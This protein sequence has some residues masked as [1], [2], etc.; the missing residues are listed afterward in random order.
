MPLNKWNRDELIV[1]FNLYCR[2]P[3]GR[4]HTGNSE[5]IHLA[6]AIGRTP[7]AVSWKMVNFA[8]LDP[9][10][11]RTGRVG[12]T[13]GSKS[14]ADVWDEFSQDWD[15]LAVESAMLLAQMEFR[16]MAEIL[17]QE[18]AATLPEGRMREALVKVRIGQSFF[19]ASVLAAYDFRCCISGLTVPELLN[20]GHI[21]PWS[22]DSAQRT[23]PSNGLCLNAVLDRAYDRG[24]LTVLP[25]RTVQLSSSLRYKQVDAAITSL[26][27]RYHG[28]KIQAPHRFEPDPALLLWHNNNVFRNDIEDA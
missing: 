11:T 10:I 12:A 13:H 1:A 5:I 17:T 19:R 21:V 3:F 23:N 2:T 28:L 24:L 22:T 26:L 7:S 25:D 15:R 8:S 18:E 20:A 27:L 14:D 9:S 4:I 6:Q 16:P